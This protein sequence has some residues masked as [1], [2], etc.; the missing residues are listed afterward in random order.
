[1]ELKDFLEK[2]K[3]WS[4]ETLMRARATVGSWLARELS[5]A[6]EAG[7][8]EE[9]LERAYAYAAVQLCLTYAFFRDPAYKRMAEV[10]YECC[11]TSCFERIAEDIVMT[12]G[13][14]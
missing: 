6:A 7:D 2:V 3:D 13:V 1:M 14:K 11:D 9:A 8:E 10:C 12:Y 4:D 5:R